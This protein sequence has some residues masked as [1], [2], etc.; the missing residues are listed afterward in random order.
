MLGFAEQRALLREDSGWTQESA[1]SQAR[2]SPSPGPGTKCPHPARP[3]MQSLA[4]T[5]KNVILNV[6][7]V[8]NRWRGKSFFVCLSIPKPSQEQCEYQLNLL[9]CVLVVIASDHGRVQR[10]G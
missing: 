3:D 8:E 7:P 6:T 5:F 10:W 2:S 1:S 9:F 4:C